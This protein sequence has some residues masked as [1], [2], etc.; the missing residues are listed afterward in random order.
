MS[1]GLTWKK[2]SAGGA[3]PETHACGITTGDAAYCWGSNSNG[4]LGNGVGYQTAPYLVAGGA[5][6]ID[7][8]AG[9]VATC[10]IKADGTA[11]CWGGNWDGR[12][13]DG[14]KT[15]RMVP[16]AVLGG[17]TYTGV[18]FASGTPC[19]IRSDKSL[20][21][22][23]SEDTGGLGN[24]EEENTA[25]RYVPVPVSGGHTWTKVV[26][27]L[28]TTCGLK[29]DGTI[30]CWGNN[31]MQQLGSA[32]PAESPTPLQLPGADVWTDI[33]VAYT[34]ACG[35]KNDGTAWC[36]GERYGGKLGDGGVTTGSTATPVQVAG[37]GTWSKLAA[38]EDSTCGIKT[39]NT[40]WCWGERSY[41]RI[42]DGGATSGNQTTPVQIAGAWTKI[43]VAFGH[44]C[45]IKTDGSA[46]C[47][48]DGDQGKTGAGNTTDRN[49]P[50]NIFAGAD[51]WIDIDAG[52]NHSC[53]I[54]TGGTAWCWGYGPTGQLGNGAG[55]SSMAAVAVSGGGTWKS[56]SE[57]DIHSCG[58]KSDDTVLCWGDNAAGE[59]GNAS[60]TQS[61]T[62]VAISG[63]GTWGSVSAANYYSCA[64]ATDQKA[65]CWGAKTYGQLGNGEQSFVPPTQTACG[66]P[67]GKAGAIVYNADQAVLQ[68]CDGAGWVGIGK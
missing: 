36:W 63:S 38:G 41:G 52:V 14:T 13:G 61:N 40:L 24:G 17:G 15:D 9:D 30:W 60:I 27:H 8:S 6:W 31:G 58:V 67:Y 48:G 23:G 11:W 4:Q 10:G 34:H 39:D 65:Y 37:G 59:L 51:T 54:K 56:I 43:S 2:I 5:T 7:L 28:E 42:G 19:A 25:Y 29:T 64:V 33:A 57:G 21:C 49:T 68:Y 55:A 45:A 26:G 18:G 22:W 46:W 12:A 32:A 66:Q 35:I 53:G 62:P 44:A 16:V 20:R 50:Y 3:T 1:G 47:W